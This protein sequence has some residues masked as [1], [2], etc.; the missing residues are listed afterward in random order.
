MSFNVEEAEHMIKSGMTF[1]LSDDEELKQSL[2]REEV[3]PSCIGR[4]E[5]KTAAVISPK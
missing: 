3:V 1:D 2:K 5:K 4:I